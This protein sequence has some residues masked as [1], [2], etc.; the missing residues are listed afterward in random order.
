[1]VVAISANRIALPTIAD[2]PVEILPDAIRD[3]DHRR[4]TV[5]RGA[6]AVRGAHEVLMREPPSVIGSPNSSKNPSVTP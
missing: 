4:R 6:A 2:R 5:R 3:H 1:M